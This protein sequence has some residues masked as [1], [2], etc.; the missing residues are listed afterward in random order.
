M[1]N[2]VLLHPQWSPVGNWIEF[3][4]LTPALKGHNLFLIHPNGTGLKQITFSSP[5]GMCCAVWSPD[6]KKLLT[7]QQ[8]DGYLVT[9]N[10]NGSGLRRLT[11]ADMSSSEAEYAW[12]Q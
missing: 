5:D 9:M 2:G 11:H 8:H 4:K 7:V 12:G 6:G 1:A 10:W 3:D